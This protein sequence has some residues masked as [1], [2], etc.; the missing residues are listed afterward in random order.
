M[1]YPLIT[2]DYQRYGFIAHHDA[3]IR[4]YQ[5][6]ILRLFDD[7]GPD[8]CQSGVPIINEEYDDLVGVYYD[9]LLGGLAGVFH[10]WEKDLT[11]HL[12]V[13][14]HHDHCIE[15][16]NSKLE[17]LKSRL[18]KF[19]WDIAKQPFY[20]NIDKSYRITNIY[21]HGP[22]SSFE[23]LFKNHPEYF[24]PSD[25]EWEKPDFKSLNIP[26]FKFSEADFLDLAAA[27]R[28][29]WVEF[30]EELTHPLVPE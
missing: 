20:K 16:S 23:N 28:E 26:M 17:D 21:K 10:R 22:G 11:H 1:S 4:I 15:N 6:H 7:L 14:C 18:K 9:V 12:N 5:N 19:G 13:L 2:K 24:H 3:Y 29:F 25:Y 30:P 8:G 27:F